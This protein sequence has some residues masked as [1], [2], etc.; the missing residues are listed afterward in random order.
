M[1]T[2]HQ[3]ILE[4]EKRW[5]RHLQRWFPAYRFSNDIYEDAIKERLVEGVR[6]VDLG[7]GRNELIDEF[8]D[9]GATAVGLDYQIHPH[10]IRT[11]LRFVKGEAGMLPF[12]DASLD[13]ISANNV[14]E[15]LSN[16]V[17]AL[18]EMQ[19]VLKP[20]GR[21]I[22]R[23]SNALH[24][25]ILIGRLIPERF[26]KRL[27]YRAFGV[28]S[29]DVFPAYYRANS[30]GKLVRLCKK[31]SFSDVSVQ[32]VEDVHTAYGAFFFLSLFY[33]LLVSF[34]PLRHLR[35]NFVVEVKR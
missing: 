2:R 20:G 27:I 8:G 18:A 14:L 34:K 10:L 26:K 31:A 25:L 13:L 17:S 19:R 21:M 23:T 4:K 1:P 33:Y 29:E 16:P 24:P 15:H 9:Y 28:T 30:Y 3:V 5:K 35:I 12:A 6:W 32:A 7:C 22:V 11:P